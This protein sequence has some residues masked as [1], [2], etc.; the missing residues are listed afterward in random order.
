MTQPVPTQNKSIPCSSSTL[1]LFSRLLCYG[2]FSD[3]PTLNYRFWKQRTS[4]HKVIEGATVNADQSPVIQGPRMS[5]LAHYKELRN[6]HMKK[7]LKHLRK[8]AQGL[9]TSH[10]GHMV[11]MALPHWSCTSA[12]PTRKSSAFQAQGKQTDRKQSKVTHKSI[13]QDLIIC[14]NFNK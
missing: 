2:T 14:Q 10:S 12:L 1:L 4:F 11:C 7:R 13:Q 5:F 9:S 3:S 8:V 6:Y